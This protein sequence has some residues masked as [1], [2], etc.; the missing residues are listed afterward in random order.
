MARGTCGGADA[1]VVL[2]TDSYGLLAR[3]SCAVARTLRLDSSL[4]LVSDGR[5][6]PTWTWMSGITALLSGMNKRHDTSEDM[7]DRCPTSRL[8]D[9]DDQG[10]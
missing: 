7:P 2:Y 4:G 1:S 8:D 3:S 5:S 9:A 6:R 10:I